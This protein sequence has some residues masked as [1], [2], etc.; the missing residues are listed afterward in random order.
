MKFLTK[1]KDIILSAILLLYLCPLLFLVIYA[2]YYT[3]PE[4]SWVIL[5]IGLFISCAGAAALFLLLSFWEKGMTQNE[6][7][8]GGGDEKIV[9]FPMPMGAADPTLN[10]PYPEEEEDEQEDPEETIEA[11]EMALEESQK[12][13][14]RIKEEL[15][16]KDEELLR[17]AK[18]NQKIQKYSETVLQELTHF[19]TGAQNQME[20]NSQIITNSQQTIAE[21]R[22]LIEKNT[23][24]LGSLKPKSAI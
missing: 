16:Q 1:S 6:P 8:E 19:K 14:S 18:E 11:L 2:F 24:T 13:L 21:Q 7:A 10:L 4:K 22:G 3:D 15:S 5:S 9:D 12:E 23:S 17:I 20:Q